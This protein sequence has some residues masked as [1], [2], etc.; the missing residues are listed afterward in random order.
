MSGSMFGQRFEIAKQTME[1][2]FESLSENDFF[3]IITVREDG[4]YQVALNMQIICSFSVQY[5]S[6]FYITIF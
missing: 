2:I 6:R 1:T 5:W 3:N 4:D